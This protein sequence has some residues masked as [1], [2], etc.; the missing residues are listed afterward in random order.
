MGILP[1]DDFAKKEEISKKRIKTEVHYNRD[2]SIS[3]T[4]KNR[5]LKTRKKAKRLEVPNVLWIRK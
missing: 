5:V 3:I 2:S 1:Y 4:R